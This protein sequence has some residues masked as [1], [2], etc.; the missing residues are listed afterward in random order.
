MVVAPALG[1]SASGEH[2]GFPGTLSI[3]T[4]ATADVLVDEEHE[5]VRNSASAMAIAASSG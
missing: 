1:V 2:A 3:G 4:D 5:L